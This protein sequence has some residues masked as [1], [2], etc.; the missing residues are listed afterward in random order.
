MSNLFNQAQAKAPTTKSATNDVILSTPE[1]TD[2]I[3]KF[4]KLSIAVQEAETELKMV[5]GDIVEAMTEKY[6]Q[7]YK[8]NKTRPESIKFG[9]QSEKLQFLVTSRYRTVKTTEEADELNNQFPN[10]V[11]KEVSYIFNPQILE[12]YSDLI[13]DAIMKSQ[14]PQEAKE[15][16]I[17]ANTKY[18]IDKQALDKLQVYGNIQDVFYS[19]SPVV[20]LKN[21]GK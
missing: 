12:K 17:V 18:G 11:G 21:I 9:N 19:I 8:Q 13:S 14:L 15:S 5:H 6:I 3:A 1:L 10:I 20:Q 16:L 4:K 2:Q 7:M